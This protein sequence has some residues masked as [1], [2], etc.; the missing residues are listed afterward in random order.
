MENGLGVQNSQFV[1]RPT[2][3]ITEFLQQQL[4]PAEEVVKKLD[5]TLITPRDV[6]VSSGTGADLIWPQSALKE[7]RRVLKAGGTLIEACHN[8]H[9]LKAYLRQGERTLAFSQLL[10]EIM[11]CMS[12]VYHYNNIKGCMP[13]N[14]DIVMDEFPLAKLGAYKEL[15]M[16]QK[17]AST[18][19]KELLTSLDLWI[20]SH[21]CSAKECG[22][23]EQQQAN[24]FLCLAAQILKRRRLNDEGAPRD[25]VRPDRTSVLWITVPEA[26]EDVMKIGK[27]ASATVFET[28]W[29]GDKYAKKEFDGSRTRFEDEVNALA[30]LNHPHI[31][32]VSACNVVQDS[33]ATCF[34]LMDIMPHDLRTCMKEKT[35]RNGQYSLP[36]K[37]SA[38]IDIML[39]ISEAMSYVHS[40]GMVHR[41]LKPENI[42]V[43]PVDDPELGNEGF[44]FAK[45]ADFGLAKSKREVTAYSHMTKDQGTRR[46]MAPEVFTAYNNDDEHLDVAFPPKAD[47]YSFGIVCFEILTGKFPFQNVLLKDLFKQLTDPENPLRPELPESYPESLASLIRQ[48]WHTDPRRRPTFVEVSTLLRYHKGLLMLTDDGQ[49]DPWMATTLQSLTLIQAKQE[50]CINKVTNTGSPYSLFYTTFDGS[51]WTTAVPLRHTMASPNGMSLADHHG[52]LVGV[53][54]EVRSRS[55][56]WTTYSSSSWSRAHPMQGQTSPS[57]PAVATFQDRLYCLYRGERNEICCTSAGSNLNDGW[58]PAVIVGG[59][60]RTSDGPALASYDNRLIS[61][62][63]S[64]YDNNIYWDSFDGSGWRGYEQLKGKTSGS[65]AVAVYKEQLYL[66]V[67]GMDSGKGGLYWF[68]LSGSKWSSFS[69]VDCKLRIQCGPSLAVF[70]NQL[71]CTLHGREDKLYH[72]IFDGGSWSQASK[73][74]SQSSCHGE[75]G[76][77]SIHSKLFCV[78]PAL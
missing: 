19:E 30:K 33:E 16:L 65:P 24:D 56:Y 44:V 42:L 39:Q 25:D 31:V 75:Q 23:P 45:V 47:V 22:R 50:L 55:L 2:H 41:D 27:G 1:G 35:N 13:G 51:S 58:T 38:A 63:R 10:K 77:C 14:S 76:L 60:I 20:Q 69:K 32:K 72:T 15:Y 11:W 78:Y 17:E 5:Y 71:V 4:S 73:I 67:L 34:F 12:V 64:S 26:L 46:W 18:D 6:S 74:P 9:C 68:K 21:V 7:L 37:I 62:I 48:C 49:L 53:S 36:F 28:T 40:Q 52:T 61:V 43:K 59:N 29:L 3:T 54:R 8:E 66:C 70:N 57:R